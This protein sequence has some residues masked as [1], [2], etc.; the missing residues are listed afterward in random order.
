MKD[1]TKHLS[2]PF[3]KPL[4]ADIVARDKANFAANFPAPTVGSIPLAQPALYQ[5]PG[6]GYNA[7]FTFP[8]D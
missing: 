6:S 1:K 3:T 5:D 7:N 2:G 8:Q 4:L